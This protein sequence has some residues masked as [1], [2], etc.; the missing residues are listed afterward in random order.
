MFALIGDVTGS[1]RALRQLRV[2]ED[3]GLAV[4]VLQT[5]PPRAADALP[6][7]LTLEVL[8][9]PPGGGPLAFWRAHR[10]VRRAARRRPA[11]LYLASDLYTLPALA[12][13]SRRH[14]GRLVYD[15]RE[16]YT[17]LDS[18][19]GRPYVGAVW[20]AV[21]KRIVHRADAV[22]TVGDAIADRLRDRY[23]IDRPLGL[24]N[25][26]DGRSGAPPNRDALRRVQ[27]RVHVHVAGSAGSQ[28][29]P[30]VLSAPAGGSEPPRRLGSCGVTNLAR[31]ASVAQ[32]GRTCMG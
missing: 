29:L 9:V 26:P 16:L 8:D 27:E 32:Q 17:A 4:T 10:A 22:L 5:S 23:G 1:S 21:E 13:A 18:T 7:G 31:V 6:E 28:L 19:H 30:F 20:G 24:Y 12:A 14:G 2:L 15:S 3:A 11:G 25:A